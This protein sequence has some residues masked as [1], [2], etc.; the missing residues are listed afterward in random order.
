MHN[1]HLL[2]SFS[3]AIQFSSSTCNLHGHPFTIRPIGFLQPRFPPVQPLLVACTVSNASSVGLQINMQEPVPSFRHL[4]LTLPYSAIYGKWILHLRLTTQVRTVW[5]TIS[6]ANSKNNCYS[7][8]WNR[9][10]FPYFDKTGET[11]NADVSC[12]TI[13]KFKGHK[14]LPLYFKGKLGIV[15]VCVC[16]HLWF[17]LR[18]PISTLLLQ[19]HGTRPMWVG[20]SGASLLWESW[21]WHYEVMALARILAPRLG[22]FLAAFLA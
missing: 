17:L 4:Y 15:T 10:C 20:R 8:H 16:F 5:D 2:T 11:R 22:E 21:S 19:S 14:K 6:L 3:Q 7:I 9:F 13:F 1:D 12:D 18:H